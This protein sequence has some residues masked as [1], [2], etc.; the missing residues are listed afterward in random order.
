M[1]SYLVLDHHLRRVAAP[2]ELQGGGLC[3]YQQI[4]VGCSI[5]EKPVELRMLGKQIPPRCGS[6]ILLFLNTLAIRQFGGQVNRE[7]CEF[8]AAR[9]RCPRQLWP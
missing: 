5:W 8:T 4:F 1:L 3:C 7:R 6:E 2:A 9:L